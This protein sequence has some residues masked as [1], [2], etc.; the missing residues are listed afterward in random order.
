MNDIWITLQ[1]MGWNL[2][3]RLGIVDVIDI[4]IVAFILYELLLLT[5]H[6]RGSAL[7]KGLFAILMISFL[8]PYEVFWVTTVI[9][10]PWKYES[11]QATAYI[12]TSETAI[13]ETESIS[14]FP[15]S[16]AAIKSAIRL[17]CLGPIMVS[18]VPPMAQIT[19]SRNRTI[20]FFTYVIRG[21]RNLRLALSPFPLRI[22]QFLL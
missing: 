11:T 15:I 14:R 7:L 6:T 18:T 5:R 4:L 20:C 17:T 8:S 19:A 22:F 2:T 12:I 21:M 3:H 9:R 13:R 10:N 16:P 1:N